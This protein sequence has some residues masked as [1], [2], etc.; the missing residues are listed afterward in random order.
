MV[1]RSRN[2]VFTNESTF[3][4]MV[5]C[6][7]RGGMGRWGEARQATKGGGGQYCG[8]RRKEAAR[9]AE[10][11]R[12]AVDRGGRRHIGRTERPKIEKMWGGEKKGGAI[13]NERIV[14]YVMSGS[15]G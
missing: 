2:K 1:P 14:F 7:L 9:R 5:A 6:R 4:L 12:G 3:L 8:G 13:E 10:E 11:G 15:G